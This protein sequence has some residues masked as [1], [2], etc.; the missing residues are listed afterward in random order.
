MKK[1]MIRNSVIM[2]VITVV[3]AVVLA[4]YLRS[5]ISANTVPGDVYTASAQGF[6]SEIKVNVTVNEGKIVAV[7]ADVSGETPELGGKHGPEICDAIVAA[8]TAEGVDA[9]GGCTL[10]TNA[11]LTSVRDCMDQAGL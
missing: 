10:T 8:G 3:L 7:S 2:A 6:A 1:S 5:T 4:L 11:I 9:I